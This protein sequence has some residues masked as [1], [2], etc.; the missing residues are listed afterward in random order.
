MINN[1]II[2]YKFYNID[3]NERRIYTIDASIILK[4]LIRLKLKKI[5][6]KNTYH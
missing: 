1:Y 2:S 6:T 3:K 4:L 5:S